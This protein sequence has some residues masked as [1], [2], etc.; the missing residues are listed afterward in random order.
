MSAVGPDTLHAG[1]FRRAIGRNV[2]INRMSVNTET[3][4]HIARP[5]RI[6][7]NETLSLQDLF[8]TIRELPEISSDRDFYLSF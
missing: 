7:S 3:A 8:L 4:G 5:P 1:V 2:G 6:L